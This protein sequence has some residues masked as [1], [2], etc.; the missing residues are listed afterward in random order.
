MER[1]CNLVIR[2]HCSITWLIFEVELLL[3][4]EHTDFNDQAISAFCL[5][6]SCIVKSTIWQGH[7][8]LLSIMHCRFSWLENRLSMVKYILVCFLML[9]WPTKACL[10]ILENLNVLW[11]ILHL[12]SL[13]ELAL[14][15][16]SLK[17]GSSKP[18]FAKL[19][20]AFLTVFFSVI[21]ENG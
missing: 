18:S 21:S 2:K 9:A 7:L 17:L 5:A 6:K 16:H 11:Q 20:L 10:S 19:L 1:F 12:A 15:S 14:P 13:L 3:K 8:L 4:P